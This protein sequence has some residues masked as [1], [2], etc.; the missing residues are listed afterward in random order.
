[1]GQEFTYLS[2]GG[3]FCNA[4]D[5]NSLFSTKNRSC[6]WRIFCWKLVA[7]SVKV[8][9]KRLPSEKY[10]DSPYPCPSHNAK[11]LSD[12]CKIP[13]RKTILMVFLVKIAKNINIV[14]PYRVF[15]FC[16]NSIIFDLIGGINQNH[17]YFLISWRLESTEKW[18]G[19]P[20]FYKH[21]GYFL[22]WAT[23]LEFNSVIG[24]KI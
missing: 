2:E 20:L 18:S 22:I 6:S 3:L 13:E 14:P 24:R 5:P 11:Y 9:T 1:M 23:L 10:V 16:E 7:V 15:S 17:G 19:I 12:L 21:Y 8:I 4:L